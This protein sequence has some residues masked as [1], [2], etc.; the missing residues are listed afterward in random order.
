MVSSLFTPKIILSSVALAHAPYWYPVT[1]IVEFG[2]ILGYNKIF[3]GNYSCKSLSNLATLITPALF[4][5]PRQTDQ[6]QGKVK[7][8]TIRYVRLGHIAT[9]YFLPI[10]IYL[11]TAFP[12]HLSYSEI[13][14]LSH[15]FNGFEQIFAFFLAYIGAFLLYLFLSAL[16]YKV[17]VF[18]Y[19]NIFFKFCIFSLVI[20]G[21]LTLMSGKKH[22][23]KW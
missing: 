13:S 9:L 2:L 12:L 22:N 20:I 17:I 18:L 21:L 7:L 6:D 5:P 11:V 4:Q 15:S 8:K 19:F 3:F 1:L 14:L 10:V 16:Y 23:L